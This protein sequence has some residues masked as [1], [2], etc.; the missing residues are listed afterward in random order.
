MEMQEMW[1]GDYGMKKLRNFIAWICLISGG[2]S[3]I[4]S[5][6]KMIYIP[7]VTACMIHDAG[8]LTST[9]VAKVIF[10][11]ICSPVVFCGWIFIALWL[12]AIISEYD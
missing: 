3:A 8:V 2:A 1:K 11:C 5:L 6:Y 9:I 12:F 4:Y 7:I 10:S